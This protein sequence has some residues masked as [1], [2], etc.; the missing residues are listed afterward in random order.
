MGTERGRTAS[1]VSKRSEHHSTITRRPEHPQRNQNPK[2]TSNMQH[3]R[4][5]LDERQTVREEGV[6]DLA[7]GNECD[8]DERDVPA[9]RHVRVVIQD[10]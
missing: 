6:E 3:Q 2:E 5:A 8:E 9:L 4:H 10:Y 7:E 1:P